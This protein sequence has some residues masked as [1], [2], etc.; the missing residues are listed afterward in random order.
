[1]TAPSIPPTPQEVGAPADGLPE[2]AGDFITIAEGKDPI[3]AHVIANALRAAGLL[4]VVAD[5]NAVQSNVLWRAGMSA[6]VRVRTSQVEAAR[7]V[8]AQFERGDFALPGADAAPAVQHVAQP[9]ALYGPDSAALLS[10]VFTPVFGTAFMTINA[11][12]DPDTV[13]RLRSFAWLILALAA[14]GWWVM[15]P[16]DG[17]QGARAIGALW[18]FTLAWYLLEAHGV[19][20]KLVAKYGGLYKRSKLLPF[21]LAGLAIVWGPRFVM[22]LL[23]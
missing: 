1:M 18:T 4:A 8:L 13:S 11:V 20:R 9:A 19:S 14:T 22:H 16:K 2:P 6:R 7:E 15:T 12:R 23:D 5:A 10:L 3:D 17:P 21:V